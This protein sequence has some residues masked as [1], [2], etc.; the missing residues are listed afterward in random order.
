MGPGG[1]GAMTFLWL[2]S[3]GWSRDVYALKC[4]LSATVG[5]LAGGAGIKSETFRW[6]VFCP[7]E[8][9]EATDGQSAFRR[10]SSPDRHRVCL[11]SKHVPFAY[12]VLIFG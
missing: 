3:K 10:Q 12:R 9:L 2:R 7:W 8:P 6:T 5:K 1:E 4:A 11:A